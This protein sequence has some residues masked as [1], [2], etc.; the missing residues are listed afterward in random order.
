MI[1]TRSTEQSEECTGLH[2]GAL[3]RLD[4]GYAGQNGSKVKSKVGE[5]LVWGERHSHRASGAASGA[6]E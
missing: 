5:L 3:R 6:A 2:S 4:R 1:H